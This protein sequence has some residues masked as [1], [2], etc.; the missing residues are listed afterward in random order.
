MAVAVAMKRDAVLCT[1]GTRIDTKHIQPFGPTSASRLGQEMG[2][3]LS[4]RVHACEWVM[5][6][7]RAAHALQPDHALYNAVQCI[8]AQDGLGR[9][10]QKNDGTCSSGRVRTAEAVWKVVRREEVASSSDPFKLLKNTSG[11]SRGNVPFTSSTTW[12]GCTK[13]M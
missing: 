6:M 8:Q 10:Q 5:L 3:I 2:L 4:V 13:R 12:E 9:V 7:S 1:A 11:S